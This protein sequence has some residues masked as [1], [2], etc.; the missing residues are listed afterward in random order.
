MDITFLIVLAIFIIVTIGYTLWKNRGPKKPIEVKGEHYMGTTPAP[1]VEKIVVLDQF[2]AF[3]ASEKQKE[4]INRAS[5]KSNEFAKKYSQ[6]PIKHAPFP[7]ERVVYNDR[8]KSVS[9]NNEPDFLDA[10]IAASI[11]SSQDDSSSTTNNDV[12]FGGGNFGGGGAGDDYSSSDSSYSSSDSS[13]C[14]SSS[15]SSYSSND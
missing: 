15:D 4:K 12:S 1:S 10:F 13:S 3:P 7:K 11:L 6:T 14:D 2:N 9:S 5:Q 8:V